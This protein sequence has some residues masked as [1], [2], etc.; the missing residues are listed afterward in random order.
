MVTGGEVDT[1]AA[2]AVAETVTDPELPM[3]TLAD[4]GVL[5]DVSPSGDGGVLVTITPTYSGCPALTE[6]RTDLLRE[7][8][9]AG[10]T[11]VRIRTELSPPWSSSWITERGRSKLAEHGIH[12]PDDSAA[13]AAG[14]PGT[15]G[16]P[17]PLTLEP[18]RRRVS[19]PRCAST[20]TERTSE[21]SATAC[22]AL[23]RCLSC[24]EPF[25]YFKEI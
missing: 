16:G 10:F 14:I 20:R 19:C 15:A 5:R 7:L 13:G 17:V 3:L 23:Y 25:E 1:S 6:M 12:P 11:D 18:P 2:R 4:L 9:Q 24:L 22:K 21:F 8:N